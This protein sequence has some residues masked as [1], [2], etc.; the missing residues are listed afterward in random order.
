MKKKCNLVI[1]STGFIGN[2]VCKNISKNYDLYTISRR[3]S[4]NFFSKKH[5]SINLENYKNFNKVILELKKKYQKIDVFFLAGESSVERSIINSKSSINNSIISFHNIIL[6]LR[7]VNSTIVLASSGSVYDLRIKSSFA[8]WDVVRP[9]SPYAA[10]KL[11]SEAIAISYCDTYGMDIRI[12]RIFS[13]FGETM[14]RFFIYDLV[15]KLNN[16]KGKVILK[17]SGNQ[18]RDYLH[19]D[20]VSNGLFAILKKG[21]RGEIYN[22]CRG[23]P[24]KLKDLANKVKIILKKKDIKIIWDKKQTIGIRDCWYGKNRKIKSIGFNFKKPFETSLRSTVKY[25]YS[26]LKKI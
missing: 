9:P 10:I 4:K 20:D 14:N 13:V 19:V 26:N 11:A 18:E 16:S 22:L 5:F 25:I 6:S 7:K 21:S 3:K 23:M 12:A 2:S 17:G 8:E 24:V 15:K 1:G